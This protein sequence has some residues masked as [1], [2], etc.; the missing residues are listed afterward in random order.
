MP[1][2]NQLAAFSGNGNPA[3]VAISGG[4]DFPLQSSVDGGQS[5]QA[6]S[7]PPLPES[8]GGG[9][10]FPGL[11]ILPDGSLLALPEG[12]SWQL[13][14]AGAADWCPLNASALPQSPAPF[15]AIGDRLWWLPQVEAAPGTVA[16]PVS[17]PLSSLKCAG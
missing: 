12:G 4:S 13:L 17:L 6:V 10:P 2:P 11:Q 15:Q 16:A 14:P 1:G 3:A 7:L 5:W 9:M 8:A